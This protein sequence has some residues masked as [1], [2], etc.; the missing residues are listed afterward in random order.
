MKV[1][2]IET[3]K[4]MSKSD[5]IVSFRPVVKKIHIFFIFILIITIKK[6][7]IMYNFFTCYSFIN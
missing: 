3:L 6:E 2:R 5:N 4:L 7:D 1:E